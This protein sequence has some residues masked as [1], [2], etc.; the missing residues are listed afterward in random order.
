M[1]DNKNKPNDILSMIC[2]EVEP[3]GRHKVPDVACRVVARSL[4]RGELCIVSF[5]V[6]NSSCLL[7]VGGVVGAITFTEAEDFCGT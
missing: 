2:L 7:D 4:V 6:V 5:T 1:Y 3:V